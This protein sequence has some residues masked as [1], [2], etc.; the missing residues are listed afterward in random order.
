M[1]TSP[2]LYKKTGKA[3]DEIQYPYCKPS[4]CVIPRTARNLIVYRNPGSSLRSE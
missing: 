3:S 4:N 2:N 1:Y